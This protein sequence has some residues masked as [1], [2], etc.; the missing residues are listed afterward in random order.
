MST[1]LSEAVI[2]H[3]DIPVL[4]ST[5][6]F[7][8]IGERYEMYAPL[9]EHV[10]KIL[11]LRFKDSKGYSFIYTG[12]FINDDT[13]TRSICSP[14]VYYD[15]SVLGAAGYEGATILASLLGGS[16]LVCPAALAKLHVRPVTNE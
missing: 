14:D 13:S 12:V 5:G 2:L 3:T 4:D 6:K 7:M 1:S 10:G 11:G 9:A 16:Y 8:E 15:V